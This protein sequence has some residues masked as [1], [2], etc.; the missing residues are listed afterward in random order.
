MLLEFNKSPI[1]LQV[2]IN[3]ENQSFTDNYISVIEIL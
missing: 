1:E 3:Q 2:W